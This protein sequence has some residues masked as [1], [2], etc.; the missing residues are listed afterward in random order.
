MTTLS[1]TSH[2]RRGDE[3]VT[4]SNE[5]RVGSE[6][7]GVGE[8]EQKPVVATG[9]WGVNIPL[10]FGRVSV[11]V[12]PRSPGELN[13]ATKVIGRHPDSLRVKF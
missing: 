4:W 9:T 6:R 7:V 10:V 13:L 3:R 8:D 12:S 5:I 2:R 1:V 11:G